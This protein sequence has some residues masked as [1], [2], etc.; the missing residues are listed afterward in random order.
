MWINW[1]S[2]DL[3]NNIL[4]LQQLG[5]HRTFL[6]IGPTKMSNFGPYLFLIDFEHAIYLARFLCKL[7]M[8]SS[9]KSNNIFSIHVFLVC[10]VFVFFKK[11]KF[12]F[13]NVSNKKIQFFFFF[14]IFFKF[15]LIIVFLLF[16]FSRKTPKC[17]LFTNNSRENVK[18]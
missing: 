17:R 15:I 8:W 2:L 14:C 18:Y 16:F 5:F 13:K 6:M 1:I 3:S 9:L 10:S 4:Y 7:H 12:Y 11:T